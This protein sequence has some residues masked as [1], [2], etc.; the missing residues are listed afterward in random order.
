MQRV[1][2]L[3]HRA[4]RRP[5]HG[6]RHRRDR[7]RQ[8]TG[9]P[10]H[11]PREPARGRDRSSP[12]TAP[13]SPSRCSR[14][15]SSATPGGIHRGGFGARGSHRARLRRHA[16]SRRDRHDEQGGP[17][18]AAARGRS[19]RGPSDRRERHPPSWTCA[20]SPPPTSD[21]QA[22]V[23][24]GEFRADLYYRL[25]VH[26]VHL[27]P[28]RERAGDLRVL[29]DFFVAR[30]GTQAGIDGCTPA[31]IEALIA[32]R[33][34]GQRPRARTHRPAGDRRGAAAGD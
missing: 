9:R 28:L 34:S 20:S 21:L 22:A 2:A 3:I 7:H 31:A 25:N 17:G 5:G 1:K 26:R 10:R 30:D 27:P 32:L 14:A 23:E 29:I 16:L 33:L 18:Q 19:R 15:S 13:R 12:S 8:G 6:P 4:A 11:P 24:A